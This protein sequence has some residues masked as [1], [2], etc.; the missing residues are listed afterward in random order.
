MI[1]FFTAMVVVGGYKRFFDS[2]KRDFD[3]VDMGKMYRSPELWGLLGRSERVEAIDAII[4]KLK[5]QI[6]AGKSAAVVGSMPLLNYLINR[7][8]P[9]ENPWTEQ[10]AP[11]WIDIYVGKG[12]TPDFIVYSKYNGREPH[13]PVVR[14]G[15]EPRDA[16]VYDVINELIHER[17]VS[18][19]ENELF[20]IYK[21]K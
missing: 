4:A 3:L 5:E 11:H 21:L 9:W 12:I 20:V 14:S 2:G 15:A 19:Y 18:I 16:A 8:Y 17:Y 7:E 10:I 1:V 6:P 13:W